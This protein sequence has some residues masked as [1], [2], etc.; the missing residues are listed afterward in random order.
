MGSEDSIAMVATSETTA[1]VQS[2]EVTGSS[3]GVQ[4]QDA[5]SALAEGIKH[6]FES[7]IHIAVFSLGEVCAVFTKTY[8]DTAPQCAE[9]YFYYGMALLQLVKLESREPGTV[10]NGSEDQSKNFPF[11]SQED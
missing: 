11:E 2:T 1:Q 5:A 7:D 9:A 4:K 10:P 3:P 8:G 6:L